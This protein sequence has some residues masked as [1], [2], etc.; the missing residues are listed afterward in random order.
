[1]RGLYE[2]IFKEMAEGES[3]SLTVT[4]TSEMMSPTNS[5]FVTG[6]LLLSWI[7]FWHD[8]TKIVIFGESRIKAS[9][10]AIRDKQHLISLIT[11]CTVFSS[12]CLW[13]HGF[14]KKSHTDLIRF[15]IPLLSLSSPIHLFYLL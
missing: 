12:S 3:D 14:L 15:D 9:C 13:F 7:T 10:E 6:Q 5:A 8:I 1:M 2:C 4:V 11:C